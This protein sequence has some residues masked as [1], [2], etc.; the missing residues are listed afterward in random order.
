MEG[1]TSPFNSGTLTNLALPLLRNFKAGASKTF[2]ER[3][4][5]TRSLHLLFVARIAAE[6]R[7]ASDL[8]ALTR[9]PVPG[10][11]SPSLTEA[12]A[13]VRGNLASRAALHVEIAASFARDVAE[14]LEEA[15]MLQA[16]QID[17][18]RTAARPRSAALRKAESRYARASASFAKRE[19]REAAVV[20]AYA[21]GS[22]SHAAA[23]A[24]SVK[25]EAAF[26]LQNAAW[27]DAERA[28]HAAVREIEPIVEAM[29][30]AEA[31]RVGKTKDCLR[32]YCVFESSLAANAQ[33]DLQKLASEL[34]AIAPDADR[35][36]LLEGLRAGVVAAQLAAVEADETHMAR[37]LLA[38]LPPRP[39]FI[40]AVGAEEGP[41]PR[42]P[43][44]RHGDAP[45]IQV[46][47]FVDFF[48]DSDSDGESDAD[49][50]SASDAAAAASP[51]A[52]PG[53]RD[54]AVRTGDRSSR[55]R[56]GSH[57]FS[58]ADA[59]PTAPPSP[60]H[61][62]ALRRRLQEV[63]GGI[64]SAAQ[65]LRAR[66]KSDAAAAAR[67]L[68]T[69]R[70]VSAARNAERIMAAAGAAAAEEG[71]ALTEEQTLAAEA[72]A[73]V[74]P[75]PRSKRFA[76]AAAADASAS[77]AASDDV[78]VEEEA[79]APAAVTHA[80]FERAF[81]AAAP[82]HVDARSFPT[83]MPHVVQLVEPVAAPP[84]RSRKN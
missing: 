64:K 4:A 9:M 72:S 47:A 52:S 23:R 27:E 5:S 46:G 26:V 43:P 51:A 73:P 28:R 45:E 75:R 56:R 65:R 54:S 83:K 66:R 81:A 42:V 29:C 20:A 74:P 33:Y 84:T 55:A 35:T 22:K 7:Y 41:P 10:E 44:R 38:T 82:A 58:G 68:E 17:Q 60:S 2:T 12:L 50:A 11:D 78:A 8:L 21:G 32:R 79:A 59:A 36:S 63:G 30:A 71:A 53:A 61:A 15:A 14:P 49:V 67:A 70:A 39:G 3:S 40:P 18:A 24:Y 48:T 19:R 31:K 69:G 1:T 16:A 77:G 37:H 34:D 6:R 80:A 57:D 62:E 25:A 13:S 76:Y